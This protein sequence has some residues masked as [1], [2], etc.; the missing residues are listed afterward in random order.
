MGAVNTLQVLP[1]PE[2]T[3]LLIGILAR[4]EEQA[5]IFSLIPMFV[6]AGLGLD[7]ALLPTVALIGYAV[8]FFVLAVG[9]FR[10][11]EI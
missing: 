11:V 7:S 5:I 4:T 2:L 8:V 1:F 3:G 6:F 10:N 9:R